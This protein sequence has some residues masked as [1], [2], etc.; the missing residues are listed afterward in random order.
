MDEQ[1]ISEMERV[2]RRAPGSAD[3][4]VALA[5]QYWHNGQQGAAEGEWA[6][7]CERIRVGCDMY[8]DEDFVIRVRRWPPV[9]A[10]R[11]KDFLAMRS[12]SAPPAGAAALAKKPL[13]EG[14]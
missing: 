10:Q 8:A 3:I 1:A 6:F 14:M 9:M 5:A 2:A 13:V 4:R 11:L 7:A 12:S